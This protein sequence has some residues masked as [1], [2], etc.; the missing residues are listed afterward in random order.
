MFDLITDSMERPLREH[1]PGSKIV[2]M[3]VH[4]LVL[5]IVI[6][7]P[8]LT[9]THQLPQL[10]TMTA[11]VAA[12]PPPP[13]PPPPPA[14]PA[15]TP[16]PAVK[17]VAQPALALAAPVTAPSSIQPE[18]LASTSEVGV[19][20]GVE[21]GIAGGSVGAIVGGLPTQAPPPPPPVVHRAPVRVG[22]SIT[23]PALV[24]QVEPEYPA[25]ALA[26]GVTG[27]VILEAEVDTNGRVTSV[28]V[29]RS[30][31]KFLDASAIAALQ[32]W[33][34]SPLIL[35]GVPVPFVLTV[36]FNF[37]TLAAARQAH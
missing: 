18:K 11:F 29:L 5:A 14:R 7:V 31:G 37:N 26:A 4:V 20:G 9:A 12:P 24:R 1:A 28:K 33:R 13:P 32:Q 22:G 8:F 30:S 36:T 34:Y 2:A 21:G 10:E 27:L 3:V 35:S 23:A 25:A 17:P 15:A 6:V 19:E 16:R